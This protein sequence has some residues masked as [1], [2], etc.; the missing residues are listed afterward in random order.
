LDKCYTTLFR[1]LNKTEARELFRV[2]ASY[3]TSPIKQFVSNFGTWQYTKIFTF[4]Y[5]IRC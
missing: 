5:I 3:T 2:R 1:T 4:W